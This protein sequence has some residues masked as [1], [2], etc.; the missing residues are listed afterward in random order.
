MAAL[1]AATH[2][3]RVSALVLANATARPAW[4]PDNPTGVPP[5]VADALVETVDESWG[6]GLTMAAVNPT[7]AGDEQAVRTWGRFLRLAA[8]PSVA[9]AVIRMIFELDVRAI[10]PTIRVPTLVVSRRDALF[11]ATAGR[12]VAERSRERGSSRCRGSTTDW[13]WGMSIRSSTRS[14][15]SSLARVRGTTA[16]RVL[17]T[18]LF[19]D[20]VESTKLAAELGDRGW[21]TVLDAHEDIARR[22]VS[23]QGGQIA[24]FTGDGLVATFDGPARAVRCALALR[25]HA[26][27]VGVAIRAG[28]H[29]GEIERRGE[30]VAGIGVHIAARVMGLAE[31]DEVLVSRTVKDLVA[32]SGLEFHD[33]GTHDL[34]GVPERWHVFR[35]ELTTGRVRRQPRWYR[36]RMPFGISIWE[37]LILL[38][39]LLLIFGAKRLPEM[40]RSLGK[41]MREF[42]DRSLGSRSRSRTRRRRPRPRRQPRSRPPPASP[43]SPSGKRPRRR[44]GKPFARS[45]SRVLAKACGRQADAFRDLHATG[46]RGSGY[47]SCEMTRWLPRRLYHGE[48]ATLVEHLDE[49]RSRLIIACSRSSRRSSSRSPST[50]RSSSGSS[51]RSRTTRSS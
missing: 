6:Q 42:K 26:H 5:E 16:E 23:A 37:L 48:E 33:R 35:A 24:D 41:G 46:T 11:P 4:A 15:S 13:P 51:G 32:G 50:S 18:V 38:V 49:L 27:A 2:P 1:F 12:E 31:R 40:G 17:A 19:T 34:K 3:D 20:I 21:R 10:L 7:I 29:T 45:L 8:S 30:D 39:V 22:E 28:V 47:R 14:R 25:D 44:S 9:A 43:P 36:G